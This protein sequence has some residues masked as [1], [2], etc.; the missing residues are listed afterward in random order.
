MIPHNSL[1]KKNACIW[2]EADF[3]FV[4]RDPLERILS[5][6]NYERPNMTDPD[7]FFPANFRT[8]E[9]YVECNF[10]TL[11][12]LVQKGLMNTNKDKMSRR[13]QGR[14]YDAMTGMRRY[15]IHVSVL[16][17]LLR[18]LSKR[19]LCLFSF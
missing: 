15:L 6:F 5:S 7:P 2:F 13:C 11:E 8:R 17:F 12:T 4:I 1:N 18:F 9:L 19:I 10:W 14:A 16:G 3:L